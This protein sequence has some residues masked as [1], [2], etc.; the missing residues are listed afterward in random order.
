MG[1]MTAIAIGGLAVSAASTGASFAQ[2]SKQ[3][4]LQNQAEADAEQAMQEA[5]KKLEVNYY[6]QLAI[7]KEPYELQREALISAGAQSIEAAREAEGRNLASTAGR[8]QMAQNEQQAGIRTEMGKELM[9]LQK[10][11][12]AEESRLRD[13]NVQLDLGE[14]AGAQQAAADAQAAA[15]AATQQGFQSA[16]STL[17]QG[18]A[19]VPLYQQSQAAKAMSGVE[20]NYNAAA[21]SGKLGSRFLDKSGQPIP[22]QKAL[23]IRAGEKGMPGFGGV[24]AY[25]ASQWNSWLG[26]QK[27]KDIQGMQNWDWLSKTGSQYGGVP[28]ASTPAYTQP[29]YPD[30]LSFQGS[31]YGGAPM[32]SQ[33]S[34]SP[35]Y[36]DWSSSAAYGGGR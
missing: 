18:L 13:I 21:K 31:P 25:D 4:K 7:N 29:S 26:Q 19:M 3:R 17:Q 32:N 22:F 15:A 24:G 16:T 34:Y 20:A 9:D 36:T 30:W 33:S 14:V 23:E 10:L 11:S 35:S 8:V 2:A 12:A 28:S 5:R 27:V 6:D 1:V